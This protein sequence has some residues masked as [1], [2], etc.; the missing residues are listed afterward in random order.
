VG[1]NYRLRVK[2]ENGARSVCID[3]IA[4]YAGQEEAR[5]RR[6]FDDWWYGIRMWKK[7]QVA[8]GELWNEDFTQE[9]G[10]VRFDVPDTL[11]DAN[12]TGLNKFFV[13]NEGCTPCEPP[14]SASDGCLDYVFVAK[15]ADP[16]PTIILGNPQYIIIHDMLCCHESKADFKLNSTHLIGD[17]LFLPSSVPS[18]GSLYTHCCSKSEMDSQLTGIAIPALE[19]LFN[20][21]PAMIEPFIQKRLWIW[22]SLLQPIDISSV[23]FYGTSS[24][25]LLD[26][27]LI[28]TPFTHWNIE[29]TKIPDVISLKITQEWAAPDT[30]ELRFKGVPQFSVG[31]YIHINKV[32]G[33]PPENPIVTLF[34]GPVLSVDRELKKGREEA[35]V[36]AVSNEWYLTKQNCFWGDEATL[37]SLDPHM[38]V[39]GLLCYFLG[40]WDC[41]I[42]GWDEC[43]LCIYYHIPSAFKKS[44]ES[45]RWANPG[46]GE[47][48]CCPSVSE[49]EWWNRWLHWCVGRHYKE[50]SGILPVYFEEVP[51]WKEKYVMRAG[52][53]GFN[54]F[55]GTSKWDAIMQIC[56]VCDCVF[57]CTYWDKDSCRSK[58]DLGRR[59][60]YFLTRETCE[61][62]LIDDR[63]YEHPPVYSS[64]DNGKFRLLINPL[65]R[66]AAIKVNDNPEDGNLKQK[67]ISIRSREEQSSEETKINR[68]AVSCQDFPIVTAEYRPVNLKPVEEYISISDVN[69]E[70]LADLQ[71]FASKRLMELRTP[72]VTFEA[73]FLD[74]VLT[75]KKVSFEDKYCSYEAYLPLHTGMYI[76]FEGIDGFPPS[77]DKDGYY[78]IMKITY[79]AGEHT[80]R[81]VITT[82]ECKDT[83]LI[84]PGSPKLNEMENIMHREAK[85]IEKGPILPG[86]PCPSNPRPPMLGEIPWIEVGEIVAYD[87]DTGTADIKITK[88]GQIVK[89]VPII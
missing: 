43:P 62:V 76:G 14:P 4:D 80:A 35:I 79:E 50:V 48:D 42:L 18:W 26:P 22:E 25:S 39:R 53:S 67:L 19:Y 58:R 7:G 55:Y 38:T 23:F 2:D 54:F 36:R 15:Y 75:N 3:E 10:Y 74:F 37:F 31:D 88:T 51:D 57:F 59:L 63:I 40:G 20:V 34:Y 33:N 66:D 81:K 77:S 83:D 46:W 9:I 72:N 21:N 44:C 16:E 70:D 13:L 56:N 61:N 71:Q 69:L 28:G 49:D 73:R 82:L 24:V 89:G 84:H 87:P 12:P 17:Y 65:C 78:R 86:H 5:E 8:H 52:K 30:A 1:Y 29:V 85:K 47:P 64:S 45:W 6:F 60:A 27:E 41:D 11:Y 68:L 32:T